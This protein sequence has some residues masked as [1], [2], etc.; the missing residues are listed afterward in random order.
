MKAL[1]SPTL[2]EKFRAQK[3]N[4]APSKTI[5]DAQTWLDGEIKHW[6]AITTS[7]KI[8]VGG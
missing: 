5:A 8:D 7:V 2:Q 6:Q 1:Q 4:V 3:M